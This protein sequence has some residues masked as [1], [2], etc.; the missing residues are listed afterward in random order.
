[1][2]VY[3]ICVQF[4]MKNYVFEYIALKH[5]EICLDTNCQVFVSFK[6]LDHLASLEMIIV[7]F[8][9]MKWQSEFSLVCICVCFQ[10]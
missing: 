3:L 4:Q 8:C 6:S 9:A 7:L 5:Y 2:C 10:N 1:M